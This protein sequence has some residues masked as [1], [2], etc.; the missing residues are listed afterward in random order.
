MKKDEEKARRS[1]AEMLHKR[2]ESLKN[3]DEARKIGENSETKETSNETPVEF[4]HRRMQE[5]EKKKE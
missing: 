1:K 5:L 4:I 3:S 2:I